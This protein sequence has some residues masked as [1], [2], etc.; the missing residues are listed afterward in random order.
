MLPTSNISANFWPDWASGYIIVFKTYFYWRIYLN[1]IVLINLC[2]FYHSFI[3]DLLCDNELWMLYWNLNLLY[4]YVIIKSLIVDQIIAVIIHAWYT[5]IN[6][7]GVVSFGIY[8]DLEEVVW[9]NC[10]TSPL[11][12]TIQWLLLIQYFTLL[13]TS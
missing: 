9:C 6:L 3:I 4:N 13:D 8:C 1:A 11:L 5:Y 7:D 12:S 10:Y 2:V